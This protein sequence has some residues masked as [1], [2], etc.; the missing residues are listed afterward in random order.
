M[1]VCS[2]PANLIHSIHSTA[3]FPHFSLY[4]TFCMVLF[5]PYRRMKSQKVMNLILI[6]HGIAV[7][8]EDWQ[9]PEV[10]RPLTSEGFLK[11]RKALVGLSRLGLQPTHMFSSSFERAIQTAELARQV[12][13]FTDPVH[14]TDA[15]LPDAHPLS[16]LALLKDVPFR[17]CVFCFGHEPQLSAFAGCVIAGHPIPGFAFKKAG[18]CALAFE[19]ELEPGRGLL[20]WCLTPS[21]L[22]QLKKP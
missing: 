19:D 3:L 6:R 10:Q 18:A 2:I 7:P 17:S 22:R 20:L 12:F 15:L 11:T 8:V 21:Q 4:G 1:I 13:Y 9:G 14:C 16:L 5:T